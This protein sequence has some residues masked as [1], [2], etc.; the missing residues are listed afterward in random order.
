[1][2]NLTPTTPALV[3]RNE[4][5]R[6]AGTTA[7]TLTRWTARGLVPAPAFHSKNTIRWRAADVAAFL[8]GGDRHGAV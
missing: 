7:Q 5:A 6:L 8:R 2:E 4:F 1:M 3:S